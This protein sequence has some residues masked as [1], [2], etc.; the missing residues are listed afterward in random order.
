MESLTYI[1]WPVTIRSIAPLLALLGGAM[2]SLIF[3]ALPGNKSWRLEFWASIAGFA[4][5]IIS[6]WLLWPQSGKGA[7][8]TIATGRLSQ[9][10]ILIVTISAMFAAFVSPSYMEA[11]RE[12]RPGYYGLIA[13]TAFGMAAVASAAD[14]VTLLISIETM[15]LAVYALA[16]FMRGRPASV[17]GALKYFITGAFA[18]AFLCMGIAF[19]FGSAGTTDLRIIAE[20]AVSAAADSRH[21]FLFGLA[22]VAVGLSFKV[23]AAPFHAWA[24][25]AYD[26]APTPVTLLMATG[27]KAAALIAFFRIASAIGVAGGELWHGLLWGLAALT[28]MWGNLAALRQQ[29]IKRMLAWSSVAHAGYMLMVFPSVSANPQ[30]LVRALL[31]YIVAYSLMTA[32][33][34]AAVGAFGLSSGEPADIG[35]FSGLSRKRPALAA[36]LSLFLISLAGFPPTLGFF[37]KYYLFLAVVRAGDV[38]LAVVAVVGSVISAC[39]YLR[40]VMAMYFKDARVRAVPKAPTAVP[41]HAFYAAVVAAIV[42]A[43]LAVAIFGIMPQDLVAFVEASAL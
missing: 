42:I 33:A 1:D 36:A 31:L 8:A 4:A 12:A 23:A 26:G 41:A 25:D 7:F 38:G 20:R 28:I 27:V 5:A 16:G 3:A 34:F 11:R 15:S 13:F 39:Y 6:S 43:A 30:G 10:G 19:I 9:A 17:E 24:P 32:G 40:P 14:L 18:A 2:L 35:R 37:G 22:M 29:N 21:I